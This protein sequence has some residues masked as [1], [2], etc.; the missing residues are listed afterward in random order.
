MPKGMMLKSDGF[1]SSLSDPNS[2]FTLQRFCKARGIEYADTGIP[3]A[4]DTFSD[5]GN[6]FAKRM[7]PELEDKLVSQIASAAEGF[8][9][10]LEDGEQ[11]K[12][13]RVVLA[14]GI[15]HFAYIPD[16]LRGLPPELL[17]HSFAHASLEAFRGRRVAVIG[18][19]SSAIDLA[20]LLR[21]AGAE[22]Q[23]ISRK[24]ELKF[25]SKPNSTKRSLWQRIR[26]PQSGLGPGLKSRFFCDAPRLF[27]HMPE[28][29]RLQ[30]V[31]TH[32]GPSGGW[33]I[34]DRLM[35]QVPLLL[36]FVVEQATM[37]GQAACLM[38]RGVDGSS[39]EVLADHVIAATG[40]K[41]DTERLAMLS[42]DIRTRIKTLDGSPELS[43]TF[44]SSVPGLYF[45]GV[46]AANS[47]GP[48]MRF[49]FGAD[50]AARN[51]MRALSK[52][53]ALPRSVPE[54][55]K[56]STAVDEPGSCEMR[57][58]TEGRSSE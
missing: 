52:S 6:A 16:E 2:E 36:G 1:A 23:L 19:G 4:L 54:T 30:T 33:F 29:W 47:F 40:Y 14:V 9:V 41:V 39:R 12:A 8:L 21:E 44:E 51:I 17:S 7:V 24:K 50:F 35:E 45:V 48:L 56:V 49:A 37:K 55:A 13:R 15:T 20:V 58:S 11:V 27:R 34:K 57:V 10:R 46:S 5:Y 43:S 53:A 3:V 18:G 26:N 42:S 28:K 32:L 38:L 31:R 22:V 25:H